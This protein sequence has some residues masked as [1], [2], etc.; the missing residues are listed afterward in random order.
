MVRRD[1]QDIRKKK[2]IKDFFLASDEE[3]PSQLKIDLI[4]TLILSG[5]PLGGLIGGI[6]N[7]IIADNLGRKKGIFI[8]MIFILLGGSLEVGSFFAESWLLLFFGRIIAG[9]SSGLCQGT[10]IMYLQEISPIE[11][12]GKVSTLFQLTTTFSILVTQ[13]LGLKS[14]L[15]SYI[16]RPWPVCFAVLPVFVLTIGIF[17]IPESPKYMFFKK[18]K[19]VDKARND[20]EEVLQRLRVKA[21]KDT[22]AVLQRLRGKKDVEKELDELHKEI[23]E[24]KN[25]KKISIQDF[26]CKD[27]VLRQQFWLG[28]LLSFGKQFS[29]IDAVLKS[30]T[31]EMLLKQ[32]FNPKIFSIFTGAINFLG[33]LF[34]CFRIEECGRRTLLLLGNIIMLLSLTSVSI[35]GLL[36]IPEASTIG[37]ASVCFYIL[38]YAVGPGAI[39]I[40]LNYEIASPVAQSLATATGVFGSFMFNLIDIIFFSCLNER[41]KPFSLFFYVFTLILTQILTWIYIPETKGKSVN[42]I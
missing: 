40:I 19:K 7:K 28:V 11:I 37:F 1:L 3:S 6:L 34:S 29:G 14:V 35:C 20:T 41:M 10:I 39:P 27:S 32:T 42:D 12:K 21:Q 31:Q 23:E 26:V 15:G 25:L 22:E 5:F 36:T 4:Y 18:M 13:V 16:K 38:G 2:W 30:I 33:L 8:S 9:I 24:R 17:Y